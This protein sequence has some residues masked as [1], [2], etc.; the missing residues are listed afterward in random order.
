MWFSILVTY[1]G[2]RKQFNAVNSSLNLKF[3][4]RS[5]HRG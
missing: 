5:L 4:L 1:G 3:T 2:E